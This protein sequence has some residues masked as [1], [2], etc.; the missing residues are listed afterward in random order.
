MLPAAL[1][2]ATEV[3]P[4]FRESLPNDY[5]NYTGIAFQDQVS[6]TPLQPHD[7]VLDLVVVIRDIELSAPETGGHHEWRISQIST[8]ASAD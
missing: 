7:I 6:Y 4:E 8:S 3:D 1:A 5:L 2:N